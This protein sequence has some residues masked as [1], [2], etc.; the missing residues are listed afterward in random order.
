MSFAIRRIGLSRYW[1]RRPLTLFVCLV[2]IAALIAWCWVPPHFRTAACQLTDNA[3][4]VS[5]DWIS[6]PPE[7]ARVSRLAR[8]AATRRLRYLYPFTTYIKE[9]GS[10][11][12]SYEH[13]AEFVRMFRSFNDDTALLAWIGIPVQNPRPFGPDGW[14]DL[15]DAEQRARI[16]Q[17]AVDIVEIARFD[18]IHLDIEHVNNGDPAYLALLEETKEALG[19]EHRLSIAANDWL[20]TWLNWLPVLG[21]YKWSDAYVRQVAE[22]V[23]Q[24]AVMSYDSMM[25]MGWLYRLWLREQTRGFGS[26]L[27]DSEVEL[28]LGVS[29]SRERTTTHKPVA[30]NLQNGLS[31][32][33]AGIATSA[34][35]RRVVSG[36]AIYASWEADETDWQVWQD[37]LQVR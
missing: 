35:A 30:E 27:A 15:Q 2:I 4:W 3:A 9:N 22:R 34:D 14:V 37:W 29:V 12:A 5:V 17:F 21:G 36:V 33:C 31:G 26:S 32:I 10:F 1:S 24:I 18:G 13:A 28:L 6:Q 16:V 7:Q 20:P 19:P 11:N 23:D 8:D 25:P